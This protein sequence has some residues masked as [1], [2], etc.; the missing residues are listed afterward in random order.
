MD[1]FIVLNNKRLFSPFW[2]TN[3]LLTKEFIFFVGN[4]GENV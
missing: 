4:K 3:L 1:G 2:S